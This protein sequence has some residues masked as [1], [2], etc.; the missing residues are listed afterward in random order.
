MLGELLDDRVLSERADDHTVEI[1]REDERGV[2]E[3][4]ASPELQLVAAEGERRLR[5]DG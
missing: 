1:G 5:R 3:R 2:P 4:L